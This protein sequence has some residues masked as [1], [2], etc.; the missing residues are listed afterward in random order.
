LSTLKIASRNA[1]G[2]SVAFA[3]ALGCSTKT[4]VFDPGQT[5]GP[6][7]PESA[8]AFGGAMNQAV[9]PPLPISGGT[10]VT[11]VRP[12]GSAIAVASDPDEDTVNVVSLSNPPTLLGTV[13]LQPGD[14]PGRLVADAAGRVHVALRRGGAIA[15]IMP[16]ATGVSL[17]GRQNVCSAPR[18]LDYDAQTDSVFVA[19]ATGE[20]MALP[21]AGGDAT[22]DVQVDRDLRDV[23]VDGDKVFVTRFRSAEILTLD[24]AGAIQSR[25]IP[26]IPAETTTSGLPDAAWRAVHARNHAGMRLIYQ[27]ASTAPI[28]IATPPGVSSYGGQS[29]NEN[30]P[31]QGGAGGVVTVASGAFDGT[32]F[33]STQL[34]TNPVVDL[35]V[36]PLGDAETISVVGLVESAGT[37]GVLDLTRMLAADPS[38]P[39]AYVA[40]ADARDAANPVLVVQVHGVHPGVA[41]LS[42]PSGQPV[43]SATLEGYVE[44]PQTISHVD[45]GFDVFHMPT[46]AGIAC[47]NCHPEGGDD[48]HTWQFQLASGL[49]ARRTQQLRGGIITPSA[50]YHWDGDMA[51]LQVLCDEVFTHRMGGDQ[52]TRTQTPILARFLNAMP[53]V[54]VSASLDPMRVAKGQAIF[55]DPARKCVSCHADGGRSTLPVNQDIGKTDMLGQSAPLQVPVLVG[56]ADRAPYMH[57]G[58]AKTLLDRLDDPKCAGSSHGDVSGLSDDDKQNLVEYLESL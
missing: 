21:A 51:D 55:V 52:L 48:G 58:C 28:D 25:A 5:T 57:D 13:H 10:L 39:N 45:T 34:Q 41:V 54:P 49:R 11:I 2:I 18:G 56:V 46:P 23:V 43:T 40:I 4:T 32:T 6:S 7:Q 20:L 24:R 29:S 50:P 3:A 16:T 9:T 12:D 53:R 22:L 8:P 47:M 42:A 44:L 19:C 27:L 33:S 37:F 26:Q 15:T 31:V 36:S 38:S 17:V 30:Q 14:E 35:A 1:L